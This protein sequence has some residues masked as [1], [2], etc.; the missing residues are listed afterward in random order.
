M[1]GRC[2]E[3]AD[4]IESL[5]NSKD[6]QQSYVHFFDENNFSANYRDGNFFYQKFHDKAMREQLA[7]RLGDAKVFTIDSSFQIVATKLQD[8]PL[9]SALKALRFEFDL[10]LPNGTRYGLADNIEK[11]YKAARQNA[12]Q[13]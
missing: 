6:A 11:A 4:V 5:K 9:E 2:K 1:S 3:F 8:L 10:P 7:K 13:P 12:A